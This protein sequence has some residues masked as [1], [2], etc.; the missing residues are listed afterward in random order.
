MC[1]YQV[2]ATFISFESFGTSETPIRIFVF[3]NLK[4]ADIFFPLVYSWIFFVNMISD[5]NLHW[6]T[7][8]KGQK[9]LRIDN[10]RT[11]KVRIF[12][13]N[14]EYSHFQR[15]SSETFETLVANTWYSHIYSI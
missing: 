3:R 6:S 11:L 5:I 2:F 8:K 7:L 4:V 14:Y 15:A 13:Q 1:K 9:Q 10:I 12:A